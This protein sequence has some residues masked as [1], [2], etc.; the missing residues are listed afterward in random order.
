M[1]T[2]DFS[3]KVQ[4]RVD[5]ILADMSLSQK[6]GQM[7]QADRMTCTPQDV[8]DYALGSVMSS[9]GSAPKDNTPQGWLAMCES[10]W[11]ASMRPRG[12]RPRIPIIYGLDAVHGHNNVPG[13]TI[14][15]HNIG[16]GCGHDTTLVK[17]RAK[18]TRREVLCT[19]VDW[20][21]GPNLA[22]AKD[23]HWGRTYESFS[24]QPEL[25]SKLAPAVVTTLQNQLNMDSVVACAKHWVGD[26]G[27]LH[28]IDQGDTQLSLA[29]LENVHMQPF[30]NAIDTGVL[31]IMASFSSWNG[32]KCHAHRQLLTDILKQQL[33]FKGFVVSDMQG[34]DYVADDFYMAVER[35]VNAGIDMFMVPEN[36]RDFIA[37]LTT[38]VELGSVSMARIND[39]VR[40]IILVKVAAGLFDKPSPQDRMWSGHQSFGSTEHRQVAREVVSKTQVLLKNENNTLPLSKSARILV[41]GKSAHNL[42]HQCGGFTLSWQGESGNHSI[43]GESIWQ[44]ITAQAQHACLHEPD[45]LQHIDSGKFDVAVAVIGEQPYAEGVGDIHYPSDNIAQMSSQIDGAVNLTQSIGDSL[46]LAH[47][48]PEDIAILKQ[49]KLLG[50][51]VVTLLI[52][53][54]PL[55]VNK[56]L[57]LSDAFVASWLPGSEGAGITDL[58]FGVKDFS[59]RLS[60]AWPTQLKPAQNAPGQTNEVLFPTGY[61]LRYQNNAKQPE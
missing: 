40:R 24:E 5:A 20:V 57:A 7:T 32:T 28:G 41:C 46:E 45:D 59:G 9:A 43:K 61:G 47:L 42:G 12:S 6:I 21:F 10:Y 19:G 54:R 13:A 53:G 51:P 23:L 35:S 60:F 14:F 8:F 30:V 33:G 27:T 15:P 16:M 44:A 50:L 25:I 18:I 29:Q 48:Y 56:E 11:Q 31:T 39:A 3:N 55:I 22:V 52:S 38:H 37:H 36:W 58:L 1:A 2:P 26:G 34:I 49:L 17:Q 4:N